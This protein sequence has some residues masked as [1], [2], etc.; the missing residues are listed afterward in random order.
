MMLDALVCRQSWLKEG[1]GG[2]KLRVH[3]DDAQLYKFIEKGTQ[4]TTT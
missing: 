1:Y 4:R 2:I 3:Q